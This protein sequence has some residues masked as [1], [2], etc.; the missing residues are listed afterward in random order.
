MPLSGLMLALTFVQAVQQPVLDR[1]GVFAAGTRLPVRFARSMTG[2]REKPGTVFEVQGMAPLEA[3]GCVVIPA[4]VPILGTI[5]AS[6]PGRMFGRRGYLQVRFDSM[7]AAPDEWVPFEAALDSLEWA[8]RASWSA[9]GAVR[10]KPRSIRGLVGT[11]GLVGLAGAATGLGVIPAVAFAGLDLV[12]RGPGSQI[13]AGQR[14]TIRF[15]APLVV[16][17]PDRCERTAEPTDRA[18]PAAIPPLPPRATNKR[19]TVGGDPINLVIKGGQAELD[20]AFSR[21]GWLEAKRSTFGALAAEAEALLLA[22]RDAAAPMSHEYYQGRVEDLRFERASASARARHHVR[23]W[24]ADSTGTLWAAAATEDIGLLVS[25]RQRTVTHRIAPDV[26][27]ER[28]GLVG[29]LLAGGCAVL[30]GYATLPGA[31]RSGKSVAGQAFV[32]DGRVAVLRVV[33][34]PRYTRPF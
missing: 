12:L 30:E 7:L 3:G 17:L 14:G 29:E 28:E 34:C 16:P 15:T 32:T 25:A 1:S 31:A 27:R 24:K 22:K 10:Q 5:V 13:L 4:F 9:Q 21:A 8:A 18:A 26:D 33:S 2:G 20:S 23:L 19:G 11:A 6:R